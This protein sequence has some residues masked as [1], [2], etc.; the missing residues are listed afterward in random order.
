MLMDGTVF[1][2]ETN[3]NVGMEFR[4]GR[5]LVIQGWDQGLKLLKPGGKILLIIPPSLAYGTRGDPP[6]IPGNASLVF[7]VELLDVNRVDPPRT[8]SLLQQKK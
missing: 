8:P 2:E 5:D 1:D 6:K 7:E 4:L 3:R